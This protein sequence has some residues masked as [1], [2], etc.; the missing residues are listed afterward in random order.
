[1]SEG[2]SLSS[3]VPLAVIEQPACPKCQAQMM[4][5][6]ASCQH[7]PVQPCTRLTAL[8]A[9]TPLRRLPPVKTRSCPRDLTLPSSHSLL[10][11]Q[12]CR[13]IQRPSVRH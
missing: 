6:P 1:M 13:S 12:R 10:T 3:I 2:Q 11:H 8:H 4:L 5:A 9:I 7:L